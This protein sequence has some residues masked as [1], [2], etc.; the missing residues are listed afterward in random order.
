MNTISNVSQAHLDDVPEA[1]LGGTGEL[2]A[3]LDDLDVSV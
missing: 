3:A 2:I 1:D